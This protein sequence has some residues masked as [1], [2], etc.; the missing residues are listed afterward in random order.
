MR[1]F[2]SGKLMLYGVTRENAGTYTCTAS[3]SA[4]SMTRVVVFRVCNVEVF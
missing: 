2:S 3:N 4:G 1:V